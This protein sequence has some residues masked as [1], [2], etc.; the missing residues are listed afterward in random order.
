MKEVIAT[1]N[2][3]ITGFP[4]R[5]YG[6]TLPGTDQGKIMRFFQITPVSAIDQWD[7]LFGFS[8]YY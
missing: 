5:L 4:I 8:I 2:E 3:A 1:W 7:E 6:H